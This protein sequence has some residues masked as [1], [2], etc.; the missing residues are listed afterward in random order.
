MYGADGPLTPRMRTVLVAAARGETAKETAYRLHLR[1]ATV[2]RQ[3]RVAVSRLGARTLPHA[4]A[5]AAQRGILGG[6]WDDA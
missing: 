5:I 4:V 2:E 1:P 6:L 3:R